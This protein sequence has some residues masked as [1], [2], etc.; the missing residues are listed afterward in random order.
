MSRSRKL[1]TGVT[2]P[3]PHDSAHKH[4]S[5]EALYIDDIPEPPGTLHA[6][7]GMSEKAHAEITD[8]NLTKVKAA[9]GVVAVATADDIPG[10][11]NC[12]PVFGDDPIFADGL[13]QYAGQSVFA[14]AAET[15]EQARRAARLGKI[16][17][18][19]LAPVITVDEAMAAKSFVLPA[20]THEAGGG[21][22]AL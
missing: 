19:E 2:A 18:R 11:N 6:A 22:T 9:P 14:V 7:F 15:V 10:D 5:G 13:V 17:Y 3:L 4:V 8:L 12:A 20:Y 16:S 1:K 21:A